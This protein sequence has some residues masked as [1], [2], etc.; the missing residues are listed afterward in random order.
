MSTIK[1]P[2][3]IQILNT[4]I[5]CIVHPQSN[6]NHQI[7][8]PINFWHAIHL[9]QQT[10]KTIMIWTAITKALRLQPPF[11]CRFFSHWFSTM[12]ESLN[13]VRLHFFRSPVLRCSARIPWPGR[14]TERP[15]SMSWVPAP[16]MGPGDEDFAWN[17]N[18]KPL[19]VLMQSQDSYA[20]PTMRR[21]EK[22]RSKANDT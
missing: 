10:R 16:T 13:F 3:N 18:S 9:K 7:Q 8:I 11:F 6:P 12:N 19:S 1:L 5:Y 15:R 2:S 21:K 22:G 14:F 17:V 20:T 4:M